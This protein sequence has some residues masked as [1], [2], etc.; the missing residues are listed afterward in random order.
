[1]YCPRPE[2]PGS[3]QS[4]MKNTAFGSFGARSRSG[5]SSNASSIMVN[6]IAVVM[7]SGSSSS[8][9]CRLGPGAD[10][11]VDLRCTLRFS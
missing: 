10:V 5:N 7:N 6:G 1:M 4:W 3:Q 11:C 9:T 8:N 2:A